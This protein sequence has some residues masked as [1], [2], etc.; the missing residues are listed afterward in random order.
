MTRSEFEKSGVL[1]KDREEGENGKLGS[2]VGDKDAQ[3]SGLGHLGWGRLVSSGDCL[4]TEQS[5]PSA[6]WGCCLRPRV[7]T[8]MTPRVLSHLH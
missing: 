6:G 4:D 2:G 3:W 5:P 8:Q 1:S 7:L